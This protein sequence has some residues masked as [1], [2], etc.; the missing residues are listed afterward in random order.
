MLPKCMGRKVLGDR[1]QV[2][3]S[4]ESLGEAQFQDFTGWSF[5]MC[6]EMRGS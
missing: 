1:N 3:G 6:L 2:V 5:K 4:L